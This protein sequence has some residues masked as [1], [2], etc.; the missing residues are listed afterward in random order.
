MGLHRA[1][2]RATDIEHEVARAAVLKPKLNDLDAV[3]IAAVRV[4][5]RLDCKTRR[6][7][8]PG[9]GQIT[10]HRDAGRI[11]LMHPVRFVRET[12]IEP[13]TAE[14][15]QL[16]AGAGGRERFFAAQGGKDCL[17]R[18]RFSPNSG[19]RTRAE[20]LALDGESRRLL[21][22]ERLQHLAA[23]ELPAAE[24]RCSDA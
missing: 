7:P 13:P 15:A 3:E 1:M 5:H 22:A 16:D 11:R 20:N 19:Q 23:R 18:V 21:V 17:A 8:V 14:E 6:L 24:I 10:T 12:G 4:L 9:R 2:T